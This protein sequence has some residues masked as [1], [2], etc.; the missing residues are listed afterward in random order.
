MITADWFMVDS[1]IGQQ[2]KHTATE[3]ELLTIKALM[4]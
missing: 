1:E 3:P 4:C 2:G